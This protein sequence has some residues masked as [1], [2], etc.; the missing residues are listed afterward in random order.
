MLAYPAHEALANRFL[1]YI[2]GVDLN[3]YALGVALS[4]SQNAY[5]QSENSTFF[6]PYLTT[7]RHKAFTDR[8][9]VVG[10]G[11]IGFRKV[12][13]NDWVLG[14]VGRIQTLGLGDN[15]LIGVNERAWTIEIAPTVEY[16][17]WPIHIE[18]K[19]Y[20]E[21]LDRHSGTNSELQFS[22][23]IE[24]SRGHLVP[25]FEVI[26]QSDDFT[27][28]YYGVSPAEAIAGR[29]VYQPGNATNIGF[30]LQFGYAV[31]DHW[32]LTGTI[33]TEKL[34]SEI[35]SSPLIDRDDISS[36]SL[37][38]SYNADIFNTGTYEYSKNV[39][40]T[41]VRF[42]AINAT[43]DTTLTQNSTAGV[44]GDKTDVEDFLGLSEKKTIPQIDITMRFSGYHRLE[45][46]YL[47][48]N[49]SGIEVLSE[50]ISIGDEDFLAG[51]VLDS[52]VE[53][54][55]LRMAYGYSLILDNQ[56]ELGVMAGVHQTNINAE[57][58]APNT[59]QEVDTNPSPILPVL[60]VYG[61]VTLG[62]RTQVAAEIQIFRL[63]FDRYEGSLSSIRVEAQQVY[64]RFGFGIGYSYYAM[65]LDSNHKELSGT[66]EFLYHGP[67]A[68]ASVRF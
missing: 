23:P 18:F 29:P 9:L 1:D 54:E 61:N 59:G 39:P 44:P 53:T 36:V 48:F 21:I 60:G 67:F 25:I 28:Y 47:Q 5:K 42:S 49:R 41:I 22:Y 66:L 35:T 58:F 43:F 11:D 3:N 13:D 31:T 45:F 40:K 26:Y 52:S 12:F 33:G 10:Q 65:D 30:K 51:T 16:R 63:E 19:P 15:D 4:T 27:R 6:Y 2:R 20:F 64:G 7:F 24:W 46:S 34:D 55:I 8:P 37:G 14:V 32:F 57:F 17:G 62:K 50:D 38:L 68:F 56:K